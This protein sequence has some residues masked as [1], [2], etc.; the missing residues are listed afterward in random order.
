MKRKDE[1]MG[2][3]LGF[4]MID[5]IE[6]VDDKPLGPRLRARIKS[7]SRGAPS[8]PPNVWRE[9][10]VKPGLTQEQALMNAADT[11]CGHFRVPR[12]LPEDGS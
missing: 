2:S 9:D 4:L 7:W 1:V 5:E 6:R 3:E 11:E 12:V 10:V 8:A